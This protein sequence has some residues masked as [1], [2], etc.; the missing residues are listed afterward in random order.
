LVRLTAVA[1][2]AGALALAVLVVPRLAFADDGG[3]VFRD[4]QAYFDSRATPA[5]EK[6]LDER[7][8]N[9]AASP[10]A[11][12]ARFKTSLGREGVVDLDPLTH[13]ARFVGRTDG[14]LTRPSTSAPVAIALD[15][16]RANASVFGIGPAEIDALQ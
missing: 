9:T 15:F 12:V 16:L 10:S 7:E 2:L 1:R 8:R 6:V 5:A 11:D 13:T 4:K 14:F 3:Q